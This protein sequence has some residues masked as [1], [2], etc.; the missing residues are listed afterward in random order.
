VVGLVGARCQGLRALGL[1]G[2]AEPE[3][4]ALPELP[5]DRPALDQLRDSH[6]LVIFLRIASKKP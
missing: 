4:V 2:G 6:R 5:D 3:R 1:D